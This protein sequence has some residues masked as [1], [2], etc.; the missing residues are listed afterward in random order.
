MDKYRIENVVCYPFRTAILVD[1][2][3]IEG[4]I[5]EGCLCVT[6]DKLCTSI[7]IH[8]VTLLEG[9]DKCEMKLTK[10]LK[11]RTGR[12]DCKTEEDRKYVT[13]QH[14]VG[15]AANFQIVVFFSCIPTHGETE[16][17]WSTTAG[18]L[19]AWI[20]SIGWPCKLSMELH[21]ELG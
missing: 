7:N 17:T 8:Q 15:Q 6:K 4:Q 9:R 1:N 16:G 2:G 11:F 14:E 13:Q 10:P 5:G 12:R 18:R 3:T 20:L 19:S 21:M